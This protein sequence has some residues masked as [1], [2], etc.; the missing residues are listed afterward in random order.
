M[1]CSVHEPTGFST[2]SQYQKFDFLGGEIA[3]FK[4]GNKPDQR[5]FLLGL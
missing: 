3:S 4:E 5:E 2:Q 1:K